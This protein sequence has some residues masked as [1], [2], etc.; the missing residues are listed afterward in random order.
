MFND[1][2]LIRGLFLTAIALAFGLESLRYPIGHFSRAGPGLFP[3]MISSMLLLIG[4]ITIVR[5]RFMER[6]PL[7]F[8]LK[9]IG[10]ILASL[11]GFA[12]IS[13][14]TSVSLGIVFLVFFS[15]MAGRTYSV[16][17]NVKVVAG[18]FLVGL[19]FQKLL[20]LNLHLY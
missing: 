15:T 7:D 14:F 6:L 1:R 13:R 11:C 19:A 10:I 17:R 9:N 12:L 2:N 18:L 16:L 3:L 4:I 20:G 8:N 5:A